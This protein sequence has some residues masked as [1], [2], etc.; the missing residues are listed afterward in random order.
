M[1]TSGPGTDPAEM[2]TVRYWAGARAAAGVAEERLAGVATVDDL[3]TH[4]AESRPGLLAVLPVCSVLV[5]GRASSGGDQ[6]AP[7]AVV[8]VLPP[9]AGG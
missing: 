1:H 2:V 9:F 7:G 5:G 8:E 3:V 6:I 4:L